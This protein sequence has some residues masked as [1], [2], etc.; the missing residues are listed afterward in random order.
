MFG[1]DIQVLKDPVV[2]QEFIGWTENWEKELKKK[3]I[4]VVEAHY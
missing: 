2:L 1:V 3:N 4:L